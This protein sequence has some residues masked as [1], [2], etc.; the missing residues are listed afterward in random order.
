MWATQ[1]HEPD[2]LCL[3]D[4]WGEQPKL[5]Y[6]RKR[7]ELCMKVYEVQWRERRHFLHEHPGGFRLWK[8]CCA[9]RF[10]NIF[11]VTS[12]VG[13]QRRYGLK[14]YEGKRQGPEHK[15]TLFMTNAPCIAKR[16]DLRCSNTN[17][18]GSHDHATLENG[19]VAATHVYPPIL[20][21]TI[22]KGLMERIEV[23]GNGQ[24]VITEINADVKSNDKVSKIEPTNLQEQYKIVGDE[25][26]EELAM[27][28]G[29]VSGAE[30]DP[31]VAKKARAEE[32]DYVHKMSLYMKVLVEEYY[33]KTGRAPI[34]VRWIDVNKRDQKNPYCRSRLAAR[35]INIHKRD[36]FSSL[37][38]PQ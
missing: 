24:F 7:I 13:E 26:A 29:D 15:R 31:T 12:V 30:L 34:I 2:Q 3:Y 4:G 36:A 6:G 1:H 32:I 21:R 22:C 19:K 5:D 38:R 10:L 8:E 14:S 20:H 27:A 11:G 18:H 33:K 9:R 28:W 23:G 25:D 17:G 16:L 37:G 35:E